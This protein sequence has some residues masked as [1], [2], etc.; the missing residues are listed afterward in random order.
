MTWQWPARHLAPAALVDLLDGVAGP[1]ARRHAER[2]PVC[3]AELAAL[4]AAREDVT[5]SGVPDPPAGF[6]EQLS[7]RV[8]GGVD[9]VRVEARSSSRR[10]GFAA[11]ARLVPAAAAVAAVIAVSAGVAWWWGFG[12]PNPPPVGAARQQAADEGPLPEGDEAVTVDAAAL[13][14]VGPWDLVLGLVEDVDLDEAVDAGLW[15][16]PGAADRAALR[17]LPDEQS[18]LVRLI[19]EDIGGE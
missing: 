2:C 8:S 18:E 10:V 19:R 6:W 17:L 5:S 3:A 9:S 14:A 7:A 16:A 11:W 1:S 13:D 15:P 12:P 4:A